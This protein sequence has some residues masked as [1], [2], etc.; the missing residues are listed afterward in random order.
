MLHD[1]D[2]AVYAAK[3]AGKGCYRVFEPGMEIA[4]A[5]LQSASDGHAGRAAAAGS[6]RQGL[7]A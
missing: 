7:A 4:V 5:K 2:V 3:A 6:G 1:A